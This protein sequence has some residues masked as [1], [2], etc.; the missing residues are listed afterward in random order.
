MTAKPKC[1]YNHSLPPIIKYNEGE[2]M[3]QA[4]INIGEYEDRILTIIKGKFGL[5]NKSDAINFVIERY[6]EELLEPALRPEYIKKL[7]KIQKQKGM[8]FKSIDELRKH[9]EHA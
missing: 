3:V 7:Q 2:N 5:K 1:L 8:R 6:E 4:I 9:I